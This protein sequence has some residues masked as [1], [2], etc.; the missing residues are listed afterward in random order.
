MYDM[1]RFKPKNLFSLPKELTLI[2]L[3]FMIPSSTVARPDYP[4]PP[5]HPL[6]PY[7]QAEVAALANYPLAEISAKDDWV[8]A[9]PVLREKFQDMLGLLPLP[10]RTPLKPVITRTLDHPE[11]TVE[12]IH[13]QASPGLYVTGNLYIP[14]ELDGPAP[15]ILYV[16]G[17]SAYGNLDGVRYG[18]KVAYQHHGIWFAQNGYVAFVIDTIHRGEIP[19]IHHGTFNYDM[20]WWKSRGYTSAGLETWT[21]MRA[22]DYLETRKEVDPSRIGMTGRSGGG[23]YS[24]W[25]AAIDERVAATVPVAGITDLWNH[26]VDGVV[27]GHC[28]CM[29]ATNTY[30]W[31]FPVVGALIAP[32]PMLLGNTDRDHIFPLDGV[33]RLFQAIVPIYEM[34]DARENLGLLITPGPHRSDGQDLQVPAL[35]WFNRHFKNDTSPVSGYAKRLFTHQ[36]LKVFDE[37][38]GDS[39]NGE[40]H[41]HF[42]PKATHCA[43]TIRSSEEW[44]QQVSDW[45]YQLKQMSF[46]GWPESPPG[47]NVRKAAKQIRDEIAVEEFYFTS[48]E[49]VDLP[50][51]T[52]QSI[53]SRPERIRM[54]V[55]SEEEWRNDVFETAQT[56]S[57][58]HSE[59]LVLFAPRGVG[60]TSWDDGDERR[61]IHIRRRFM[62]IGQTLAGMRV[63]DIRRAIQAIR[64]NPETNGHPISIEASKDMAVNTLY[65]ALFEPP[66][67]SL[68]LFD[69]SASHMQGPHYLNVL[70]V[71]DVPQM[72]AAV[73]SKT[74]VDIETN[75]DDRWAYTLEV[76]EAVPPLTGGLQFLSL[77]HKR[78][79]TNSE[80]SSGTE[81]KPPLE[82]SS[83]SCCE[84]GGGYLGEEWTPRQRP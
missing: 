75:Q 60:P 4:L 38:P 5:S 64:E 47:K 12:M 23:A 11:F 42:V 16:C 74:H 56:L 43:S 1:R 32:R 45:K 39:I 76:F 24:L 40:I 51:W 28:D 81:K 65:A 71:L 14:K 7:F 52:I 13:F 54:R 83:C 35:R 41:Y 84:I 66:L 69:P 77:R 63:W 72:L 79:Q 68:K 9:K 36:Q 21:S 53:H 30:R 48:Q 82:Q 15:T 29:Y 57:F 78:A 10:E 73:A 27:Q 59:I 70:R 50:F 46:R 8:S 25:L 18:N 58:D 31:D 20:W 62:I 49:N 6:I 61:Q 3:V 67:T 37:L 80:P 2:L 33:I 55:L 26:A 17:H 34:Y 22:I 19:G 44:E